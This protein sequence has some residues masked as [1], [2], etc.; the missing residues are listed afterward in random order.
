MKL[1]TRSWAKKARGAWADLQRISAAYKAGEEIQKRFHMGAVSRIG[2]AYSEA[3][4]KA[5][6][7]HKGAADMHCY[8]LHQLREDLEAGAEWLK[9]PRGHWS[10]SGNGV[11]FWADKE[12]KRD[13][14]RRDV[15]PPDVVEATYALLVELRE[16]LPI[17]DFVA[18]LPDPDE[19]KPLYVPPKPSQKGKRQV[20]ELL[21]NLVERHRAELERT[22]ARNMRLIVEQF[23]EEHQGKSPH[24]HYRRKRNAAETL[25][26]RVLEGSPKKTYGGYGEDWTKP[27]WRRGAKKWLKDQAKQEADR[28]ANT[29][30]AKNLRKLG[31]IVDTKEKTSKLARCEELNTTFASGAFEGTFHLEFADG[32]SFD[33]RNKVVYKWGAVCG[34]FCQFPTTFHTVR[35]PNGRIAR[36]Q[37]EQQMNEDWA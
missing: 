4:Y 2:T 31:S 10:S 26:S 36:M 23:L 19:A 7:R 13:K 30:I 8:S 32:S 33:A 37:S 15:A 25:V 16:W 35:W 11:T 28:V 27:R 22:V 24:A 21:T 6:R 18:K 3:Y 34:P 20:Y 12:G 17:A 9:D 29:F 5:K 14:W 1:P